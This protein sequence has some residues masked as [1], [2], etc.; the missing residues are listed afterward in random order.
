MD[1]IFKIGTVDRKNIP[2]NQWLKK[3]LKKSL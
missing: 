1:E 3:I 2:Q